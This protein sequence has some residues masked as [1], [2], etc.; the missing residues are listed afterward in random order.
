MSR[1]PILFR[2]DATGS[3]GYESF[4]QCLAYAAALQR[5]RR[6]TYFLSRLSPQTL[7]AAIQK[8]GNEWRPTDHPLGCEEDLD[9]TL[10][11]VRELQASAVVVADPNVTSEYLEALA[12]S[13]AMVVAIDARAGCR[14]PRGL[15]VNPLL[16]PN[17]D[18][19][20]VSPGTHLLMGS[21]YAFVRPF[22]RRMRPMRSQEPPAPFRVM[23]ALGDDDFRGQVL[24]RTKEL[25][26]VTRIEKIDVVIRAQHPAMGDLLALVEANPERLEVVTEPAEI[27]LK[28]SRTHIALTSGDGWSLE[29][30]CIGIPQLMLV[31]S[32]WHVMNA[33]RLDDEGAALNLGD[34]ESVSAVALRQAVQNLLSDASERATMSRRGRKLIDG[35]GPDRMVNAL[36]VMLARPA[37]AGDERIAA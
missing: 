32:P 15:L 26:A 14:F 1:S 28:L 9:D 27:S 24:L 29:L 8:G 18:S 7:L 22:V 31:Q 33:Q 10:N 2:C 20:T 19:Y 21:R 35:R 16:G 23:V 3:Q 25:L 4:Y 11:K 17:Q 12:E 37:M 34:C 36:E 30:A 6:G 13:G 5:R